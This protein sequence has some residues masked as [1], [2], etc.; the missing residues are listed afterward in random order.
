MRY[1]LSTY[2]STVNK[3]NAGIFFGLLF[4]LLGF[5]CDDIATE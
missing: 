1:I 5:P 3:D 4:D 2:L